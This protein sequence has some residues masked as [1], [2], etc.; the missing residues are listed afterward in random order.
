[1]C[2]IIFYYFVVFS[3]GKTVTVRK[4]ET[5]S[6]TGGVGGTSYGKPAGIAVYRKNSKIWD[7]S[8]N[9]HNCPKNLKIEKFD[10]SLH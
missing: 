5:V 2:I 8:N 6:K 4:V 1:M 9:C 3:G 7:T 10:V